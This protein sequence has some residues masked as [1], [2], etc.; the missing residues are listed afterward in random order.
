MKSDAPTPTDGKE[1]VR[2]CGLTHVCTS[3]YYPQHHSAIGNVAPMDKLTGRDREILATRD[4]KREAA[5]ERRA[6]ARQ[7]ARSVA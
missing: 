7:A 2:I 5:R 3:P 4:R 1:F 6:T